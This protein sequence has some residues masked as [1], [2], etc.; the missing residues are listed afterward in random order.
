MASAARKAPRRALGAVELVLEIAAL[1]S[2]RGNCGADQDS[3]EV[4][5]A[6]PGPAALL[7]ART[8][9]TAGTDAGP[10]RQVIDAQ[11]YAHVDADLGDQHRRNQPVDA[12][13]LHQERVLC[14]IGLEPLADAQV[15]C[16]DVRLDCFE[17]AQLHRQEEA[18]M[19]LDPPVQRQ[20]QI[21]ALA[22]QPA[23]ARSAIASAE[24]SPLISAR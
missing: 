18:V 10:G 19:L 4:D 20:D 7:P 8:L 22:A 16:C 12:R 3:A 21:G 17:P 1:G 23:L 14:A 5:V 15:E 13:N 24:A 11:E 9:M 6:L 2:R